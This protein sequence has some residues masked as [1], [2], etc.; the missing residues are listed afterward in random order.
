MSST[1]SPQSSGL[2]KKAAAIQ[3]ASNLPSPPAPVGGQYF[4]HIALL[5]LGFNL[6]LSPLQSWSDMYTGFEIGDAT[7]MRQPFSQGSF[8]FYA[9]VLNSDSIFRVMQQF[10]LA[11]SRSVTLPPPVKLLSAAAAS[12][13]L[14]IVTSMIYH[15]AMMG[16]VTK[17]IP[18]L[19]V[20][21]QIWMTGLS[22]LCGYY[23]HHIIT[24]YELDS[25]H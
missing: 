13:I 12:L 1:K 16:L 24:S 11:R 6:I 14:L 23:I 17:K 3:A 18:Y 8:F 22:L 19:P 20:I 25:S 2:Q 21:D 9:I 4:W 15:G 5:Y 10:I 7:L